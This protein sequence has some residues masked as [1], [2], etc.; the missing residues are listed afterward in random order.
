MDAKFR[1]SPDS[2][3]IARV[4]LLSRT[5]DTVAK[6]MIP[7]VTLDPQKGSNGWTIVV[8]LV[9]PLPLTD[10][11]ALLSDGTIAIVRGREY[12]VDFVDEADRVTHGPRVSFEWERVRDE[13]RD[14]IIDSTRTEMEKLREAQIARNAAAAP[15][16]PAAAGP[17][18]GANGRQLTGADGSACSG[19]LWASGSADDA[20]GVRAAERYCRIT[21]PRF[22]RA[23]RSATQR[24]GSGYGLRK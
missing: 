4:D 3:V 18:T 6:F 16:V 13:A 14:S 22:V 7:K 17:T 8:A 5:S 20:A 12:R 1:A 11:W 24:G 9:N 2:A 21:A 15:G 10:D 19:A 23:R